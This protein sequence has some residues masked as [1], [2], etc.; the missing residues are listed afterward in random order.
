PSL[1]WFG[2]RETVT[3]SYSHRD[4]SAPFDRGTIC[5]LNTGHAVNVDRKTRFDEAFNIT[6]GYSDLAQ[7]NAEYRLNDAWTARF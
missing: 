4:Y 5:D 2:E 3:A 7:L 1:A 6:D